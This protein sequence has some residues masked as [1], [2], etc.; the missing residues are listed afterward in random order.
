[1]DQGESPIREITLSSSANTMKKQKEY[2]KM[3]N[4][5]SATRMQKCSKKYKKISG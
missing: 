2:F 1:M 5:Y 3:Y 4:H